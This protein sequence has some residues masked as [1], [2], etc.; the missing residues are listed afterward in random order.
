[1]DKIDHYA[2]IHLLKWG[3]D[4]C[5]ITKIGKKTE[6]ATWRIGEMEIGTCESYTY[7]GDIITPDGK[8]TENIKS[9]KNKITVSSVSIN[10]IAASEILQGN[11]I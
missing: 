10:A 9:R 5:K 3:Q 2:K 11:E 1:M 8:N 4:K 6:Q 7:L